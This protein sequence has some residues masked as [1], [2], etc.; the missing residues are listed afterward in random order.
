M[1]NSGASGTMTITL[2]GNEA[3]V[4]QNVSGLAATFQNGPYPHVQH[5]HING[6]GQCPT[7]EADANGDGVVNTAEGKPSYGG[8]GTTFTTSGDTSPD[9]AT[10]I[11][12][13]P[14]GGN[15]TYNRTFTLSEESAQQ[16]RENNAVIVVHGLDPSTLPEPAASAQSELVPSLPLAATSPALCAPLTAVPSGGAAAGA[17]GTA[18]MQQHPWLLTAGGMALLTAA[19]AVVAR[20]HARTHQ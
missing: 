7:A 9:S 11:D 5:I 2:D 19:G 13:A 1:N 15:Y 4:S 6:Q 17:G 20:R 12:R 16:V 3:T 10:D 18:E 8:I 14:S